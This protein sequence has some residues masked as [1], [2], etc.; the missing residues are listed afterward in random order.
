M[1]QVANQYRAAVN[2][3]TSTGNVISASL[4]FDASFVKIENTGTVPLRY[5]L[6]STAAT[7]SDAE[8]KDGDSV[9][10]TGLLTSK[11]GLLTTS[12]STDG[13]DYRR[14]TVYATG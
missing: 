11:I 6:A 8:L 5:T 10:V 3:T 1:M 13:L 2:D 12:T 14:A 4:G 9:Q 7:T